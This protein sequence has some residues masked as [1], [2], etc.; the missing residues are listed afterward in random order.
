MWRKQLYSVVI[1]IET[2]GL[3]VSFSLW[4]ASSFL[5]LT[6]RISYRLWY[7]D[8]LILDESVRKISLCHKD[9]LISQE[10]HRF[11]HP[12][13]FPLLCVFFLWFQIM[14]LSCI[15][16]FYLPQFVVSK[17]FVFL[18]PVYEFIN[19]ITIDL[20]S[21]KGV[22]LNLEVFQIYLGSQYCL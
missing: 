14:N 21:F 9:L 18:T 13:Y 6:R 3:L 16:D 1:R 17:H 7:P 8:D 15:M 12:L 11:F 20:A 4:K 19:W 10:E 5:L 22:D 2:C